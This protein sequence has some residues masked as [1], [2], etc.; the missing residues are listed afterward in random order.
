M[1]R[2]LCSTGALIGR[3]NGRDYTLLKECVQRL[4]CDGY[5]FMMYS[6]WYDQ[7]DRLAPFLK[8]LAIKIPVLHCEKGIGEAVSRNE[9]GDSAEALRRFEINCRIAQEIGAK[10]LALHLWSGIHSDKNIAHNIEM[11]GCFREISDRYALTLTIE[12]VVCSHEHPMAHMLRLIREY[13]EVQFTFDTKMAQFH[14]QLDM[15]YGDAGREIMGRVAHMHI[16]DYRGGYMDW[17]SLRTLHPGEGQVDFGGLFAFIRAK[18]YEGDLTVEA[19]SFGSDGVIDFDA[20][21]RD[22]AN[23][24]RWLG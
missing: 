9:E 10:T 15:L 1:N 24:R 11:Y 2:I 20:L 3:P 19:T 12:N 17:A 16:N 8:G 5:E 21:N 14:G 18:G 13:P 7:I 4:N 22:F 6:T 23:I